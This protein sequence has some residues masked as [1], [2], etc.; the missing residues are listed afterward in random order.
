MA[1]FLLSFFLFVILFETGFLCVTL[2]V[3]SVDQ[4]GLELT[5]SH[6]PL[7][8]RIKGTCYHYL[9]YLRGFNSEMDSIM[10]KSRE[11][12]VLGFSMQLERLH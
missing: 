9:A 7:P 11:N 4:A 6:L 2:A 10:Q 5:K 8:A 1:G 3:L 12:S